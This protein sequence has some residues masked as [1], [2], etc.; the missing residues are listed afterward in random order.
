MSQQKPRKPIDKKNPGGNG[1]HF[2]AF[3]SD[4]KHYVHHPKM[5]PEKLF[6]YQ[7]IIDYYNEE[8]GCAFPSLETLTIHYGKSYNTTGRHIEDLKAV[9]LIDYPEK[10]YYVP[11]QPL[12]ADEF[13]AEF[14]DAWARYKKTYDSMESKKTKGKARMQE[15][16]K[17]QGYAD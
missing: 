1:K 12:T 11:L 17:E 16:R 9:G 13:Y 14:P 4:A 2:I 3:P 15:W 5:A 7:V 10:G 8:A 6:L